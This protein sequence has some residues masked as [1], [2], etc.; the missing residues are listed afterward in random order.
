MGE[1]GSASRPTDSTSMAHTGARP[2]DIAS[3]GGAGEAGE[4]GD[5][6]DGVGR[7]F[8]VW[9]REGSDGGAMAAVTEHR[10]E[11]LLRSLDGSYTTAPRGAVDKRGRAAEGASA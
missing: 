2:V 11:H 7:P 5:L 8:L 1:G 6:G 10:I 4:Q 3:R 9:V